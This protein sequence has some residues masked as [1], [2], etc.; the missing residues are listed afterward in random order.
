MFS[1]SANILMC[2]VIFSRI[3]VDVPVGRHENCITKLSVLSY[4]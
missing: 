4:V 3:E 2:L 1:V